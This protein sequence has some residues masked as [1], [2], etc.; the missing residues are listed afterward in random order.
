VVEKTLQF[1]LF[2]IL[3]Y[4]SAMSQPAGKS[5]L[6]RLSLAAIPITCVV[7][8]IGFWRLAPGPTFI[9]AVLALV[10]LIVAMWFAGKEP[11]GPAD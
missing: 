4:A 11:S 9:I 6:R 10:G 7:A 2:A 3:C 5:V 8:M 1:R